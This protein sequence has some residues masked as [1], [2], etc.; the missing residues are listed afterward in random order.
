MMSASKTTF[1]FKNL[2]ILRPKVTKNLMNLIKKFCEF[3]PRFI[4]LA[5]IFENQFE[6]DFFLLK[7]KR[8]RRQVAEK[9]IFPLFSFFGISIILTELLRIPSTVKE[10]K[11]WKPKVF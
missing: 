9:L 10:H 2:K 11:I 8:K 5:S 4:S 1:S 7:V 6:S 3:P